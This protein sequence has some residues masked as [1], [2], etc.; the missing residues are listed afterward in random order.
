MVVGRLK[1]GHA[2]PLMATDTPLAQMI[3]ALDD[4]FTRTLSYTRTLMAE[5]SPPVLHELGLPS[6]LK[7]LADQ[8]PKQYNLTVEVALTQVQVALP[9]DQALLLY[10]SVRE[11]LLNVVK[12][13]HTQR[14]RCRLQ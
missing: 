1:I 6:A 2:R 13:A 4:I 9:E 10:Q 5:L 14:P 8:A 3:E 12:H 7:W 11:L